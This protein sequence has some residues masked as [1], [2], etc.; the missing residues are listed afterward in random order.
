MRQQFTQKERDSESG[1][2]YFLA[3]YYSSIQARFISVDPGSFLPADPQSWN[4]YAYTQ[5]NPLKFTDPTGNELYFLGKYADGI[6]DDLEKFSGYKLLRDKVTGK[7]T[8]DW[9]QKRKSGK[10]TSYYLSESLRK[11]I[12]DTKVAVKINTISESKD[13]VEVIQDQFAK[14]LFDIDDYNVFKRDAPEFAARLLNHVITEYYVAELLPS[15]LG[16]KDR[17]EQSH[18]VGL[19]AESETIGDSNGWWQAPREEKH[20]GDFESPPFMIRFI[21]S[22]VEYDV[23]YK[24]GVNGKATQADLVPKI[25]KTPKKPK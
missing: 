4:R 10:G 16:E 17:F 8:I 7:V 19:E 23:V 20:V 22:T 11:A 5:N 13:H 3:R 2:D 6:I 18:A 15:S 24:A 25:D 12:I 1:L 21:Y 14:K 9:T